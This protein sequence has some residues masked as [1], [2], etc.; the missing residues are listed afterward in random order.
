MIKEIKKIW[1]DTLTGPD[2]KYSRKSLTSFVCLMVAILLA[3]L[4]ALKCCTVNEEIFFGFLTLG[5]GTLA[6][7]VWDKIKK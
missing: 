5:G 2:G 3:I 4:D 7:T 1:L 6:M